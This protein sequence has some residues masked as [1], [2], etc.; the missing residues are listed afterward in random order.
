MDRKRIY[1]WRAWTANRERIAD[2]GTANAHS[3]EDARAIA[4]MCL[5]GPHARGVTE[6]QVQLIE[7]EAVLS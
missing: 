2:C 3:P 7:Y 1:L 4:W 6:I 5:G